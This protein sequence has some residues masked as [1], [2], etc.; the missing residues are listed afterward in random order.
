MENILEK[1]A[2]VIETGSEEANVEFV[3]AI[4]K[5]AS[6]LVDEYGEAGEIYDGLVKHA[7]DAIDAMSTEELEKYAAPYI[8]YGQ[9]L[10]DAE[11]M[12][13]EA[14]LDE[15]TDI[16]FTKIAE[17][18]GEED[19]VK[20]YNGLLKE[21]EEAITALPKTEEAPEGLKEVA[22]VAA[23]AAAEKMVEEAGGEEAVK[24]NPE[25]AKQIMEQAVQIGNDVAQEV[26]AATKEKPAE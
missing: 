3:E 14:N 15:F 2:Q 4:Q 8:T 12:F 10:A 1:L 11:V 7:H 9:G 21:G 25:V 13:K 19:A 18:F 16:F 22:E 20:I 6:E 24:K 23:E 5:T 17:V 26:A